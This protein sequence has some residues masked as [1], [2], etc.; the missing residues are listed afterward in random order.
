MNGGLDRK[1]LGEQ[2][3]EFAAVAEVGA[4]GGDYRR[5]IFLQETPQRA[6]VGE[7]LRM[8]RLGRLE[9]GRPLCAKARLE[10]GR[11]GDIGGGESG[12]VHGLP[13][14]CGLSP[15][16]STAVQPISRRLAIGL[17]L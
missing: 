16:G 1:N 8:G 10:F 17:R 4:D 2:R 3:L 5:L 13:F 11:D 7:P 12:G 6:K 14:G 15:T 9:I